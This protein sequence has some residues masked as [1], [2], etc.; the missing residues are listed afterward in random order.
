MAAKTSIPPCC[1][2]PPKKKKKKKSPYVCFFGNYLLE[3]PAVSSVMLLSAV[4]NAAAKSVKT[5]QF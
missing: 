2:V 3:V 4:V 5:G 1:V